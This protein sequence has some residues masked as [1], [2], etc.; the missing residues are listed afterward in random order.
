M[1]AGLAGPGSAGR[2]RSD[3]RVREIVTPEG[4]PLRFVLASAGDRAGALVLDL[5]FLLVALVVLALAM[6]ALGAGPWITAVVTVAAFLVRNFYFVAFETRWQGVTPGKRLVGIRV[7]DARGGQLEVGAVLA[8]NLVRELEVW[9]PL[10]WLFAGDQLMPGAPGWVTTLAVV[11]LLLLVL[12]SLFNRDRARVGDL[13]GGT[14]VVQAPRT[15]LLPDLAA[16]PAAG[17]W[18]G[19]PAAPPAA[20]F[21]FTP[22]QLGVYGIYELQVLEGVLRGDP[23]QPGAGEAV[24]AVTQRIATKLRY[25]APIPPHLYAQF[26]RDFYTALR[27]ELEKKLLF[28]QRREDK[29]SR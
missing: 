8:R 23:S 24:A 16:A 9:Q 25:H 26:L 7:I 15:V 6:A 29:F 5:V 12:L 13:L 18:P 19:A 27:A 28:G 17:Y 10:T 3:G 22:A 21:A 14:R 4:V 2:E 20:I 1:S 11:W